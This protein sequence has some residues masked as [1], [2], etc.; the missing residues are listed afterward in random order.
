MINTHSALGTCRLFA[1]RNITS[2]GHHNNG[3]KLHS[4]FHRALSH[5]PGWAHRHGSPP[6]SACGNQS[7]VPTVS[8]SIHSI[9]RKKYKGQ[10]GKK[11]DKENNRKEKEEK[12]E[13]TDAKPPRQKE[14]KKSQVN[15]AKL[16]SF[17]RGVFRRFF[18][19]LCRIINVSFCLRCRE[20]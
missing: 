6:G 14:W 2:L 16:A 7:K 9:I 11:W 1:L 10:T 12:S 17:F 3:R 13:K 5:Q 18:C 19:S 20:M 15:W 8:G 4:P